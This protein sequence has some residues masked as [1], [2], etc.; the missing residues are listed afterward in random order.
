MRTGRR[1]CCQTLAA[2]S[3]A[4]RSV[5]CAETAGRRAPDFNS[6]KRSHLSIAGDYRRHSNDRLPASIEVYLTSGL[7]EPTFV[8]GGID[9]STT[10]LSVARFPTNREPGSDRRRESLRRWSSS[11]HD[12]K[13]PR[14]FDHQQEAA[15]IDRAAIGLHI[16][17]EQQILSARLTGHH[18]D[19]ERLGQGERRVRILSGAPLR[20][21]AQRS[22][23][24]ERNSRSGPRS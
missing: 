12:R 8:S 24:R 20:N 19:E 17:R 1:P 6:E 18:L 3:I 4:S 11:G 13:S 23:S 5:A 7:G 21:A 14:L 9:G 16:A 2:A 22:R 15:E 10:F